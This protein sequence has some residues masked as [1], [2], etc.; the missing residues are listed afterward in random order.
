M[1]IYIHANDRGISIA[2]H[3]PSLVAPPVKTRRWCLSAKPS[4]GQ[5]PPE[6]AQVPPPSPLDAASWPELHGS[7]V[8]DLVVEE[9]VG[10]AERGASMEEEEWGWEGAEGDLACCVGGVS[11]AAPGSEAVNSG[12]GEFMLR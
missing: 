7:S 1:Q 9:A 12:W 8:R 10:G 2:Q 11:R 6:R 5:A 3:A 4:L